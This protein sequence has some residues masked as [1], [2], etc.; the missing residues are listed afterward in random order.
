MAS[1]ST[2]SEK[3]AAEAA[4][5]SVEDRRIGIIV[6]AFAG[7]EE[8]MRAL[9]AK[10]LGGSDFKVAIVD[11]DWN[12]RKALETAY[13]DQEL[14]DTFTLVPANTFPVAPICRCELEIPVLYVNAKG[15][16]QYNHLLPV[17][18]HR[19][20]LLRI[21]TNLNLDNVSD[22]TLMQLL[23]DEQGCRSLE[24][25]FTFG[26]FVTPVLRGTPCEHVVLEAFVRKKYIATNLQGFNAIVPLI[27]RYIADSE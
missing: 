6:F 4:A 21:L 27:D 17:T 25:G 26:N 22:E 5:V 7:T 3:T 24:V 18:V 11:G 12:M 23:Y 20:K 10:A 8:R 16:R 2:K 19:D 13:T 9:W 15:G 1:K 14:A